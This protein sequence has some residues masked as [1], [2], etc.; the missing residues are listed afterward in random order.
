MDIAKFKSDLKE[1]RLQGVYI[2]G[3]EE[4]YLIR[5]YLG[6]IRKALD[7]D[8]TFAVF[9][10]PSYEGGD[11]DFGELFEAVK[12]P[13]MMSDYKLIEWRHADFSSMKESDLASLSELCELVKEYSYSILVFTAEGERMDFGT[14]KRPSKF[15]ST[16]DKTANIL[17]F[18][19]S[20]ET[21]L[22]GWL[23]RHFDAMGTVVDMEVL[24]ALVF[25]VGKSMDTLLSEAEKLSFLALSRG[26]DKIT[27]EDI[28]EVSISTPESDTF[29]LSNAI[30]DRNKQ[31]AFVA[32]LDL[33]NRRVDPTAVFGMVAKTFD[34]LLS[35]SMLLWDGVG[36]AEIESSLK[37][38]PYKVKIYLSA[39]KKYTP[40]SLAEITAELTR[41]DADSKYG[42]VTGYTA[43]ELFLAKYM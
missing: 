38:N 28:A 8:P 31:A 25:R 13:P 43:I 11:V 22:Y 35:V 37:M 23:K 9:N 19:K 36:V 21:Q 24:K 42:G 34:D 14:P 30:T 12:S 27:V 18:E 7:I 6:E 40:A 15:V 10:N 17:R 33:K 41:A 3:G 20:T 26:R 16:F 2:L 1:G 32:L 5:Y 4:E 29:A 39:A